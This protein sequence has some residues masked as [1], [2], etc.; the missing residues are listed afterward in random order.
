MPLTAN[1]TASVSSDC[2]TLSITDTST[3]NYNGETITSRSLS[4]A[5]SQGI[6][7]TVNFPIVLGVG[8]VYNITLINDIVYDIILT[9][10][11][12][13][14]VTGSVYTNEQIIASAC[15]AI[16]FRDLTIQNELLTRDTKNVLAL[17]DNLLQKLNALDNYLIAVSEFAKVKDLVSTQQALDLLTSLAIEV[18]NNPAFS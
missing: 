18:I 4:Y 17:P 16:K 5:N 9:L 10:T 1:F 2:K 6:I 15:N 7:T 8:D 13:V 14:V 11:P 3:A 12:L